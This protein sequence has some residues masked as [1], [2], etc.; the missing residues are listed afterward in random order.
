MAGLPIEIRQIS[1]EVG[2]GVFAR[3]DF[4]SV[5]EIMVT[6]PIVSFQ[7]S[8]AKVNLLKSSLGG[9]GGRAKS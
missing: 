6:E 3:Q 7:N 4:S 1:A 5:Y 2:K 9:G 8:L